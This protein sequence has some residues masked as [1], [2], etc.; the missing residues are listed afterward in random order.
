MCFCVCAFATLPLE[1]DFIISFNVR[2][3]AV[4]VEGSWG[5]RRQLNERWLQRQLSAPGEQE[6]LI[7]KSPA[8]G[9]SSQSPL[10]Q[11]PAWA[12]ESLVSYQDLLP[13]HPR[14]VTAAS[15]VWE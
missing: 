3:L 10:E 1:S 13:L 4:I 15:A 14:D 5:T 2:I 9:T 6:G 11:E 8:W 7:C 12:V